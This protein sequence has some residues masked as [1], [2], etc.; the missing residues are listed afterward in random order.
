[1]NIRPRYFHLVRTLGKWTPFP[2]SVCSYICQPFRRLR[3]HNLGWG[4]II[5]K[6]TS[7]AR[8]TSLRTFR[9][10]LVPSPL[11]SH[12]WGYISSKERRD[13]IYAYLFLRN[14]YYDGLRK[15]KILL[16]ERKRIMVGW[17]KASYDWL[18]IVNCDF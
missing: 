16:F 11:L 8:I 7:L 18:D 2:T 1:M 17:K 6:R 14:A 15:D 12:C 5:S 10:T 4:G 13:P 3:L 9:R